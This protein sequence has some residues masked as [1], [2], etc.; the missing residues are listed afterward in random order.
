[1]KVAILVWMDVSQKQDTEEGK[2][3]FENR[4]L[5]DIAGEAVQTAIEAAYQ[6]GFEHRHAARVSV[7]PLSVFVI[8]GQ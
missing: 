5:R 6:E 8:P 1:M 3:L 7:K 4:V 2:D